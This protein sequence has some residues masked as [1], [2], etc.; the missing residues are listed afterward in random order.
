MTPVFSE[1]RE[2]VAF[3]ST[4]RHPARRTALRA[5]L[6]CLSSR[7][8]L[9]LAVHRLTRHYNA[10]RLRAGWTPRSVALR[11]LVLL[12]RA[13]AITLA[14]S[15]IAVTS[16]L[17]GGVCLSDRGYLIIGPRRVGRGTIIHHRVTIGSKAGAGEIKPVIGENVWIGPDCV[18]YGDITVGDG[19]TIL[20]GTVI[21]MNIPS[22]SVVAGNPGRIIAREFDNSRLRSG[23]GT[24]VD[25]TRFVQPCALSAT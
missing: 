11:L 17:D 24:V 16:V 3:Y 12:G 15:D 5:W 1:I 20:P 7:G 2:D 13:L 18:I 23:L 21:S 4:L 25:R 8:L 14:K 6:A 10:L 19:A 22:R 9:V